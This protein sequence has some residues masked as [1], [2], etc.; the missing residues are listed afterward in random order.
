MAGPVINLIPQGLLDL[1]SIRS[2]GRNPQT[3]L[4]QLAPT[5]NMERWYQEA[6]VLEVDFALTAVAASAGA[7]NFSITA[8]SPTNISNGADVIVPQSEVWVLL[9]GTCMRWNFSA[10]AGQSI[11]YTFAVLSPFSAVQMRTPMEL[12]GFTV[13]DAA[14]VRAG[15]N[16]LAEPF[17]IQPG[18]TL[19]AFSHG[20]VVPAGTINPSGSL[21]LVRMR[22]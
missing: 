8:T 14:A 9:P 18:R 1:F 3:L 4:E 22:T 15:N 11:S 20:A 16:V 2:G 5:L 7:N 21:R 17:W 13:S 10:N 19:R 6:K 12:Q